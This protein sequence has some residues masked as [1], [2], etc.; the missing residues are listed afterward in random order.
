MLQVA[1]DY[2]ALFQFLYAV[3]YKITGHAMD[4]E[5]IVQ[6][7]L[8]GWKVKEDKD[9]VA[10]PQ[11]YLAKAVKNRCL[12]V[13]QRQQKERELYTGIYLP[14]PLLRDEH[15]SF[16]N[17]HDLSFGFMILLSALNP[18]ERAVFVL[19]ESFDFSYT[20]LAEIFDLKE[21]HCR[22]LFH[23]A[24]SKL[25]QPKPRFEADKEKK[26]LF[27]RK[28]SEAVT[29]GNTDLLV[30]LLKEDIEIHSDGGGKK[31]AA[32]NPIV[33]RASVLKFIT[34]IYTKFYASGDYY[35]QI[36][37]VNACPAILIC[38]KKTHIPETV[39]LFELN[40]DL[41]EKIYAIRNPEKILAHSVTKEH[42]L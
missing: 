27:A 35:R 15:S 24:S 8:A 26:K 13:L 17:R 7:I 22:Q 40:G 5:D 20:E 32:L 19:K 29:N 10:N 30:Q 6:D 31:S 41:V 1:N 25:T 34:G 2:K 9:L 37:V 3:A 12:T 11:A 4:S 33:G 14:Y 28:F 23:R 18:L 16:A 39:I 21:D 38:S 36:S 42:S